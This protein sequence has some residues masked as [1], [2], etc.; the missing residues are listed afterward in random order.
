C[1]V[2]ALL[3]SFPG[4]FT[5]SV[6]GPDVGAQFGRMRDFTLLG[7]APPAFDERAVTR[8]R[9]RSY[10]ENVRKTTVR[11]VWASLTGT[12][13]CVQAESRHDYSPGDRRRRQT[14]AT[15]RAPTRLRRPVATNFNA[16]YAG[17]VSTAH[18]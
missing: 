5:L 7:M 1:S 3:R 16:D 2:G 17:A 6:Y 12:T 8:A 11:Q 13:Q 10:P 18:R 4:R 15:S 9:E 14:G